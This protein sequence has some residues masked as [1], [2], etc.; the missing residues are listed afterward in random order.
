MAVSTVPNE[1]SP[2]L[3]RAACEE[4]V[5]CLSELVGVHFDIDPPTRVIGPNDPDCVY[6]LRKIGLH[7]K[8]ITGW[9]LDTFVMHV[10][11]PEL[12][13]ANEQLD[14]L[15][16]KAT[17][18][19]GLEFL[20]EAAGPTARQ[21]Q[22]S[23][24]TRHELVSSY[25]HPTPQRLLLSTERGGLGPASDPLYYFTMLVLLADLAFK[26]AVALEYLSQL[27]GAGTVEA[28]MSLEGKIRDVFAAG[29]SAK[30]SV[31]S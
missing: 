4:C 22:S 30:S 27:L 13:A 5:A 18:A 3:L 6:R 11:A 23:A 2:E 15:W 24:K 25:T 12:R 20:N 8:A 10:M 14:G 19:M 16:D 31:M 7:V 21:A 28:I 9:Q 29:F 17:H 1:Q 26:Y